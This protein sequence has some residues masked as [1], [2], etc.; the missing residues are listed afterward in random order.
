MI[1]EKKC[2]LSQEEK[3]QYISLL[4]PQ[5]RW[6]LEVQLDNAQRDR[7]YATGDEL[8]VI[9]WIIETLTAEIERRN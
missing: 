7:K 6:Q 1:A 2:P 5:A 3:D 9:D 4:K 8:A